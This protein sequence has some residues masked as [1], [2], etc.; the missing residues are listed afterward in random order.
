MSITQIKYQVVN[1]NVSIEYHL[2]N[3]DLY[4]FL[5]LH[6]DKVEFYQN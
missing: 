5:Y 4:N 3:V 6:S 1:R 2:P